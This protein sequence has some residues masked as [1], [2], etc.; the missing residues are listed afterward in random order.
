M[1]HSLA[2]RIASVFVSNNVIDYEDSDI[3]TYS[4]DIFLSTLL[5]IFVCLSISALFGHFIEGGVFITGFIVLRYFTGGHHAKHHWGCILAFACIITS[6]L[7]IVSFVPTVFYSVIALMSSSI[8]VVIVF[9]FAPVEH[10]NKIIKECNVARLKIKSRLTALVV[11]GIVVAGIAFFPCRII[12][13]VSLSMFA[14]GGSVVYA[15][16][17]KI[18]GKELS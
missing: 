18:K 9:V 3:Y 11:F 4:C 16:H 6:A 15:T 7:S 17:I 1:I 14:V 8:A 10:E 2:K 5:N 13:S 12:L